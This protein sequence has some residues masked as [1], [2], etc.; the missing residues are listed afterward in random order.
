[1]NIRRGLFR[2]WLV[3]SV[4]WVTLGLVVG[5]PSVWDEFKALMEEEDATPYAGV[6]VVEENAALYAGAAVLPLGSNKPE[7][8][9]KLAKVTGAVIGIP[10]GGYVLGV[11]CLWVFAGFRQS[12]KE[13]N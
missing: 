4:F 6:A 11:V 8:W 13:S 9:L 3:L 1:M 2:I 7:P 12:P 10:A 5:V